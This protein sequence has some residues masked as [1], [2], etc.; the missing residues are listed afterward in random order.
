VYS[1][2]IIIIVDYIHYSPF[3]L[4]LLKDE[5]G[6]VPAS[7]GWV[8]GQIRYKIIRD[9]KDGDDE[10]DSIHQVSSDWYDCLAATSD[11]G[12][13]ITGAWTGQNIQI[14]VIKWTLF[15]FEIFSLSLN[16]YRLKICK[17]FR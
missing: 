15:Y 2:D 1:K 14:E 16:I 11:G 7:K 13:A 17:Y 9:E 5:M 12:I 10:D 3:T 6:I 8:A 4:I